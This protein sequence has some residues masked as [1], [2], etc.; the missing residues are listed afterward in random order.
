MRPL[1]ARDALAAA[2]SV[3]RGTVAASKSE[4]EA[5]PSLLEGE[6]AGPD[7]LAGATVSGRDDRK[8]A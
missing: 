3:L 2:D 5:C 7:D 6:S 1:A 8:R 4:P